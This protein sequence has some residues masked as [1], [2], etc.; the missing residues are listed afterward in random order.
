MTPSMRPS[1]KSTP[2]SLSKQDWTLARLS[3]RS[4]HCGMNSQFM[5]ALLKLVRQAPPAGAAL[6]TGPKRAYV[7]SVPSKTAQGRLANCR[8]A[9]TIA[10]VLKQAL[11]RLAPENEVA[12][13]LA[14]R[15]R[16][17]RG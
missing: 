6:I 12:R 14:W 15:P 5:T 2:W 4:F 8:S 17:G 13:L 11:V 7:R 10:A 1:E 9:R 16:S 3:S